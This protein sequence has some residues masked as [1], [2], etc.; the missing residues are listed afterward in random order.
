MKLET[1]QTHLLDLSEPQSDAL[2]LEAGLAK[3]L[4]AHS[5]ARDR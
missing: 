1:H 4:W 5:L 3:M 2:L